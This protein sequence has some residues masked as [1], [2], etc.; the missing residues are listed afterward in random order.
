MLVDKQVVTFLHILSHHIKNKIIK[1]KFRHLRETINRHFNYVL[2][3]VVAQ[4]YSKFLKTLK[5]ILRNFTDEREM[6]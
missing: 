1:Y 2:L 6:I 3:H 4:L 5:P